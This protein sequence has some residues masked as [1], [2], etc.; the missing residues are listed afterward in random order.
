MRTDRSRTKARA[1]MVGSESKSSSVG[2]RA[3]DVRTRMLTG[4][5]LVYWAPMCGRT[6]ARAVPL[7]GELL[8]CS[9]SPLAIDI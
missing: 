3:G 7:A 6:A 1:A 4:S 8:R 9:R 5:H 2:R